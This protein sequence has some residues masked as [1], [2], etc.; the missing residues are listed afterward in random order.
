MGKVLAGSEQWKDMMADAQRDR[1]NKDRALRNLNQKV[2]V[3]RDDYENLP[4]GTDERQ[5]KGKELEAA[6]QELQ[7]TRIRFQTEV[8]QRYTS[9]TRTVFQKITEVVD[10]YAVENGLDL[11]LKQQKIDLA[12]PESAGQNIMLATTEVLYAAPTLDISSAV[13][14]RLNAAY[15]GPI[16]V[17]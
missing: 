12:A 14:E 1:E 10:V 7:Q 6:I 13:V 16:E 2:Q 17:K 4:P 11:V 9:A 5:A 3:L 15:P 8:A